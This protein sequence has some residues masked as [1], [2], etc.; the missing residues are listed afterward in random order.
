M[1]AMSLARSFF[2]FV[3]Y[4]CMCMRVAKV[5]F[6]VYLI[7]L[8]CRSK[9]VFFV[10]RSVHSC[11]PCFKQPKRDHTLPSMLNL[12]SGRRQTTDLHR[13]SQQPRRQTTDCHPCYRHPK[14][15]HELL[16]LLPAAKDRPQ[17]DIPARTAED[18]SHVAILA[19]SRQK[20]ITDSH[21]CSARPKTK[22]RLP[23]LL[24]AP[25]KET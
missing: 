23:S 5:C 18:R 17:I 25:E 22:H 6:G 4:I 3:M 16:F 14:S 1:A 13:C 10:L 9:E 12:F 7:N 11:D 2:F 8:P 20:L 15:N 21:P 19:A 24:R